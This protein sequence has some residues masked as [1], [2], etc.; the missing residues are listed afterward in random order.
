MRKIGLFLMLVL[1]FTTTSVAQF[2]PTNSGSGSEIEDNLFYQEATGI[3]Q[4]NTSKSAYDSRTGTEDLSLKSPQNDVQRKDEEGEIEEEDKQQEIEEEGGVAFF[5]AL[6]GSSKL[7]E[8]KALAEY[9]NQAVESPA[10]ERIATLTQMDPALASSMVNTIMVSQGSINNMLTS[11]SLY[12][13][14]LKGAGAS[15][16]VRADYLSSFRNCL[17]KRTNGKDGSFL[18]LAECQGDTLEKP[19]NGLD[20]IRADVDKL[21]SN[22]NY[23]PKIGKNSGSSSEGG[24]PKEHTFLEILMIRYEGDNKE[25]LLES[26]RELVGDYKLVD[27][28]SDEGEIIANTKYKQVKV[29]PTKSSTK[30]LEEITE[31]KYNKLLTLLTKYCEYLEEQKVELQQVPYFRSTDFWTQADKN[32][33]GGEDSV[34]ELLASLSIEGKAFTYLQGDLMYDLIRDNFQVAG[35]DLKCTIFEEKGELEKVRKNEDSSEYVKSFNKML[36]YAQL[37]AKGTQLKTYWQIFEKIKQVSVGIDYGNLIKAEAL[38]AGAAGARD[39]YA[40]QEIVALVKE[41][42]GT[43]INALREGKTLTAGSKGSVLSSLV[44][45]KKSTGND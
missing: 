42:M 3:V 26:M 33:A 30:F 44:D 40:V 43:V 28:D 12:S 27:E 6:H 18:A 24:D 15:E 9:Y 1:F 39:F 4:K 38:I 14:L 21:A 19:E 34:F 17:F 8:T 20:E 5:Q 41:D 29:P 45:A 16:Q 13:D 11:A 22:K 23:H 7:R 32:G 35:E 25:E 37:V 10:G 31:I 2:G 36:T